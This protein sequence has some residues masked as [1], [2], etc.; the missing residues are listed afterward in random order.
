MLRLGN[1]II[2][3][4]NIKEGEFTYGNRLYMADVFAE[5]GLTEWQSLAKIYTDIYGYN[6]K[7]LLRRV[8]LARFKELVE[9]IKFWA[10]A[11]SR[12][13]HRVPSAEELRAGIEE[14]SKA[15]GAM[16]T[17][18]ALAKDFAQDPDKILQWPWAKVYGILRDDLKEAEFTEKLHKQQMN[19][20]RGK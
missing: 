15:R 19:K 5:E 11:E 20:S 9:G 10:E 12:E 3:H 4:V 2:G 18:K 14:V 13:L 1:V 8:R 16:A 7:W 6:P 17:I